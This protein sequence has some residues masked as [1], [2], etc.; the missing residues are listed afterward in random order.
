VAKSVVNEF[1]RHKNIEF[2]LTSVL[3]S[4]RKKCRYSYSYWRERVPSPAG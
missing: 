3:N 4:Y 1:A 2:V